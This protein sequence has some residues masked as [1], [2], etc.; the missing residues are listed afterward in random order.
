MES[1]TPTKLEDAMEYLTKKYPT[2]NWTLEGV[3]EWMGKKQPI[4][5][6]QDLARRPLD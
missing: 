1:I 6:P 4:K 5:P 2:I 3:K